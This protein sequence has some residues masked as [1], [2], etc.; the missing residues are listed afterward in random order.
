MVKAKKEMR[1]AFLESRRKR[2]FVIQW[3]KLR[4]G[5]SYSYAKG[6]TYK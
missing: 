2:S 1:N 4:T 5:V 6:R 3:Q